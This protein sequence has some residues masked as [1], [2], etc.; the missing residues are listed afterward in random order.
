MSSE[1]CIECNELICTC[2]QI[3]SN[4]RDWCFHYLLMVL[5]PP[6]LL[7]FY[8]FPFC[9]MGVSFHANTFDIICSETAEFSSESTM[10]DLKQ[11]RRWFY[12]Q[13]P[14][15]GNW[16]RGS[17]PFC[18]FVSQENLTATLARRVGVNGVA[19]LLTLSIETVLLILEIYSP[20]ILLA[21][22][23]NQKSLAET[24]ASCIVSLVPLICS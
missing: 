21:F 7:A 20:N 18:Y 4:C 11:A 17:G 13:F 9:T 5:L 23:G 1:Q 3:C 8:L 19:E 16:G 6:S 12:G 2:P 10:T 24:K 22:Q 14:W 15:T